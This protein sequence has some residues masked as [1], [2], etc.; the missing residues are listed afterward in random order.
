MYRILQIFATKLGTN[1]GYIYRENMVKLDLINGRDVYERRIF[2][3]ENYY[4]LILNVN[5]SYRMTTREKGNLQ[6]NYFKFPALLYGF[7]EWKLRCFVRTD[8]MFK[9]P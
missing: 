6:L 9:S 2:I 7:Y 8:H 1:G 4:V 5:V 3:G